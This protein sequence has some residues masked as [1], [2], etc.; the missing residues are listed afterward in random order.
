AVGQVVQTGG[1][2]RGARARARRERLADAALP[3]ARLYVGAINRA[4]ELDVRGRGETRVRFNQTP[5]APPVHKDEIFD[6]DARVRIAHLKGRHAHRLAAAQVERIINDT[7]K[8]RVRLHG[9]A[10][11][12]KTRRADLGGEAEAPASVR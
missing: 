1:D 3:D 8:R 11:A 10:R 4:D 5:P 9:D 7:L 12:R 2:G 6:H